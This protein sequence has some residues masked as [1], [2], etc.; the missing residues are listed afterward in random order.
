MIDYRRE[1]DRILSDHLD[2]E[3]LDKPVSPS[4]VVLYGAGEMGRMAL[5]LMMANG[6]RPLYIVDNHAIGEITGIQIIRPRS[7]SKSDTKNKTF[8]VCVVT[9]PLQP[10]FELLHELGCVDV[11]HFYAYSQVAFPQLMTNGWTVPSPTASDMAGIVRVLLA[12]EHDEQSVADYLRLLWWRLR[13]VDYVYPNHPVLYK[14]KYFSA[15]CFP[16]LGENE[17]YVDGGAHTGTTITSFIAAVSGK[18]SHIHA[19][20]PD[21]ANLKVLDETLPLDHEGITVHKH[22][23][24]DS[25]RSVEFIGNLGYASKT[26]AGGSTTVNAITLDGVEGIKPTIIKLHLEG[27]ELRALIGARNTISKFRPVLMVLADHDVTGLY[28]IADYLCELENYRLYFCQ[29]DHCG[30]TSIF[31]AVPFER[32]RHTL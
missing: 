22:A 27:D 31:Y 25:K 13:Q 7:I 4:G 21:E 6:I 14:N 1:L 26:M 11:R 9:S 12:L 18:Y 2:V 15:P 28:D 8:V 19:F 23:L 5:D 16:E 3:K 17:V 29:H 20:E 32:L 24:Y 30:N 10:I